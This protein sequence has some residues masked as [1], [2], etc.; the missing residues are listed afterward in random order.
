[1]WKCWLCRE[2]EEQLYEMLCEVCQEQVQQRGLDEYLEVRFLLGRR[3]IPP[4]I[5]QMPGRPEE[6]GRPVRRPEEGRWN[7]V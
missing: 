5:E 1:M 4:P 2:E 7:R 3:S 6:K